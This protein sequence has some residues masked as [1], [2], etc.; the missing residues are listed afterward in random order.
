MAEQ[1]GDQVTR[2]LTRHMRLID[3]GPSQT[4]R[5][6]RPTTAT[7]E[8]AIQQRATVFASQRLIG[9]RARRL[10][11]PPSQGGPLFRRRRRPPAG[12]QIVKDCRERPRGIEHCLER[13]RTAF[14][15][16]RVGILAA[17]KQ[18]DAQAALGR[19]QR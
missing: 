16:Q 12:Q 18:G 8:E 2:S 5:G 3:R 13:C 7:S 10:L 15:D 17:G 9:D 4:R 11:Q 1:Y 6:L 19:D 14:G